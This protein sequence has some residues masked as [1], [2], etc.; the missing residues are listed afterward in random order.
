MEPPSTRI[1][2]SG[3]GWV[4]GPPV[5]SPVAA[6]NVLLWHG[7]VMTPSAIPF[8][9]HPWW[10]HF[11][12]NALNSP[13]FGC[14]TTTSWSAKTTPPP[15]GMSAVAVSGA[16]APSPPPPAGSAGS[17]P[18]ESFAPPPHAVSATASPA[19]PAVTTVRRPRRIRF[20]CDA[21][22]PAFPS[23]GD[24]TSGGWMSEGGTSVHTDQ[25]G[26]LFR[27]AGGGGHPPRRASRRRRLPGGPTARSP[28]QADRQGPHAVA[29]ERGVAEQFRVRYGEIEVRE[30]G[31]QF[32]ERG[33]A[34][35][36][37][38]WGA[39]AVVRAVAEGEMPRPVGAG[40][41]EATGVGTV[42]LLVAARRRVAGENRGPLG[43][44]RAVDRQVA[45][46]VPEGEVADRAVPAQCLLHHV[47]PAR[48]AQ[49]G[50][51]H[52]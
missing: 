32:P 49:I 45:G 5:T 46:R 34:L 28:V 30:P 41:V 10:V 1:C 33:R 51:A 31:E 29:H 13:A 27:S 20:S 4:A 19:A 11:D 37:G 16:P 52:V 3:S 26:S 47:R 25:R 24:K 2:F 12:E 7:Q 40:D 48:P 42:G 35:H 17:E 44:H 8:T 21:L 43:D 39:Q 14:V 15:S 36:P 9:A 50:R 38:Q 6:S 23:W 22:I 18:P